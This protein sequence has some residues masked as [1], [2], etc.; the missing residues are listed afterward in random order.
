V[1]VIAPLQRIVLVA[2]LFY[3]C[4]PASFG[5]MDEQGSTNRRRAWS[6]YS[7]PHRRSTESV[8]RSDLVLSASE[9]GT[10]TFCRT[11]WYLQRF[12]ANGDP[13]SLARL[14]I[15]RR[16]HQRIAERATRIRRFD[17]LRRLLVVIITALVLAAVFLQMFASGGGQAR[18]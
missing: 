4:W 14:H 10:Y 18:P 13:A 12:G 3:T 16:A 11:A 7:V 1:S 2:R 15:G 8:T 17:T 5:C 9:I 6:R